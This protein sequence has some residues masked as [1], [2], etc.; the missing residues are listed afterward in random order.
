MVDGLTALIEIKFQMQKT[1]LTARKARVLFSNLSIAH[2][3]PSMS[4][5]EAAFVSSGYWAHNGVG[6]NQVGKIETEIM[7]GAVL[8]NTRR[9]L[10]P[11]LSHRS[12]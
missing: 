8:Q 7:L 11:P 3:R 9:T 12:G 4:P 2:S 5:S 10:R 6:W 1:P